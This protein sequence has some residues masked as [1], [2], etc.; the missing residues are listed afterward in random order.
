MKREIVKMLNYIGRAAQ[1]LIVLAAALNITIGGAS[2]M[3]TENSNT[4]LGI[5]YLVRNKINDK[6]YVGQSVKPLSIRWTQHVSDA[7]H[8]VGCKLIARAIRKYKR[9]AFEVSVLGMQTVGPEL[10]LLEKVWIIKLRATDLRFGYNRTA[11]GTGCSAVEEVR[12]KISKAA[13]A[14]WNDPAKREQMIAGMQKANRVRLAIWTPEER[15]V[16]Y[17]RNVKGNNNPAFK[18]GEFTGRKKDYV[19]WMRAKA[20]AE[21]R[22]YISRKGGT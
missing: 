16:K 12:A 3:S 21:G 4:R 10:D 7:K 18:T 1:A 9:E 6:V 5:V 19:G 17:T 20:A 8:N 14:Q 13:K 15:R 11:G 22:E 2:V